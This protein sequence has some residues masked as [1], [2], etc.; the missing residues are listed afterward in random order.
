MKVECAV[1]QVLPADWSSLA[2][3]FADFNIYQTWAFG[4]IS[5]DDTRSQV[6]RIVVRRGDAVIGAAQL[7]IKRLP[8]LNA[9]LAYVYFGPLW[10]RDGADAGDLRDVLDCLRGEY[11]DRRGLEVRVVPNLP[12]SIADEAVMRAIAGAGFSADATGDAYRTLI[13]DLSPSLEALR[14][15]LAQKWRNGLN[16]GEKR[17][18][19]VEAHSDDAAMERFESLY[20][21]MWT[22]KRFEA[23]VSV[24][25]FRR[26][27]ES[28]ATREKQT[29]L[30][31]Y[32]GDEL[33]AGHVS[34]TLGEA[35][36]YL[37]GASNDLGREYKAS[38]VLQWRALEAA[39]N[40][41]A[42]WYD[43]GGI[44]PQGNPGVYHFKAGLGGGDT[45]FAGQFTAKGRGSAR[46]LVPLAERAYRALA[47]LRRSVGA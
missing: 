44:D 7:R 36:I 15:Q 39:K 41:G 12:G 23:G 45:T 38:Y 27:Q 9:G 1:D 2:A 35:C 26:L 21:A 25:S 13:L 24:S 20:D 18:V 42:K 14:R 10:R 43:L 29:I 4:E 47:P 6:S 31:A 22:K 8:L 5:A 32:V 46:Y 11:G 34:S 37:L 3:T 16:Q 19:R 40:A 17:G 28:L 30:L 33:T